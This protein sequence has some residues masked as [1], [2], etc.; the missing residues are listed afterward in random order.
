MHEV[1]VSHAT[2]SV[3]PDAASHQMLGT[4]IR[5]KYR[6]PDNEPPQ[7]PP[8]EK[9]AGPMFFLCFFATQTT[10]PAITAK[11]RDDDDPVNRLKDAHANSPLRATW[12]K[13][14]R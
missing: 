1:I 6:S 7:L 4:D 5:S 14:D 2:P 8:G 13:T 12:S 10:T 11:L 3:A 9:I